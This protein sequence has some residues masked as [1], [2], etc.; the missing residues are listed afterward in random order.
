M[1]K[2][3]FRTFAWSIREGEGRCMVGAVL[4]AGDSS[5]L[6]CSAV[7]SSAFSD[8]SVAYTAKVL[9]LEDDLALR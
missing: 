3:A 7:T 8:G 2:Y 4:A 9:S 5:S 1:Y 6:S